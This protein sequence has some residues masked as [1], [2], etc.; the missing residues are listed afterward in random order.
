MIDI[1]VLIDEQIFAR[2]YELDELFREEIHDAL[3]AQYGVI[4]PAILEFRLRRR[5]TEYMKEN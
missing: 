1:D 3:I 2:H 5:W 4:H